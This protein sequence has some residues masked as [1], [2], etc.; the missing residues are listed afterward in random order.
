MITLLLDENMVV[1][2]F[3]PFYGRNFYGSTGWS[4]EMPNLQDQRGQ[5]PT[6]EPHATTKGAAHA[7]RHFQAEDALR[8]S[9]RRRY[10]TG[11]R[12]VAPGQWLRRVPSDEAAQRQGIHGTSSQPAVCLSWT[13]VSIMVWWV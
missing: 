13:Y 11:S 3:I 7:W 8:V 1:G 9:S 2:E 10:S 12:P 6:E 4:S 5:T